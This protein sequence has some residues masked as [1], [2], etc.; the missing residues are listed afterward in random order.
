[1]KKSCLVLSVLA[2]SSLSAM[3]QSSVQM[4]GIVD[5]GVRYT[6]NNGADKSSRLVQ[7]VG[8]G[9]SQSRL[10]IN[11]NEDL[12]GGMRTLVNLETRINSDTGAAAGNPDFWRQ[13]WV[14]LQSTDFG[15]ITIGRQYNILFD[16]YTS[17]F[18]SFKYSTY[19]DAFKPELGMSLGSRQDNMVKYM[20]EWEG[21]R[22]ELQVSAGEGVTAATTNG[23]T[24]G[25]LLRYA[26]GPLAVVGA[27]QK[28]DDAAGKSV[29]ASLLGVGY[30]D[31]PLYLNAGWAKNSI[32]TGF[33]STLNAGL[34]AGISPLAAPS[35]PA[36]A[37]GPAAVLAK[38][39][40]MYSFG[41]TYQLTTEWNLGAQYWHA[42]QAGLLSTM[43][44]S[45]DLFAF[46][47]DYAFS[48]RTDAYAEFDHS[49][50]KGNLAF[51][52]GASSRSG[53]M[54]GLRHRF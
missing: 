5:G 8:G 19:I 41:G 17:T 30:T 39:R 15:R 44:G 21:L 4:Y 49:K 28:L 46:V 53:F 20:A 40:T 11:V 13:A 22:L 45:A 9:M 25:G 47:A 54:V 18:A 12:G 24:V 10:G 7:V 6:T 31:G 2:A 14:G 50:I 38:D 33:N 27:I 1:M 32:D 29:T 3:A 42:K 26:T 23:K 16:A 48:K 43:D 37:G 51:S 35:N 34:L 36:A 52:N